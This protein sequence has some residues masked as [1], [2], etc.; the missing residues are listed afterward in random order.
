MLA[1]G[2]FGK[3]DIKSAWKAG[4]WRWASGVRKP[5]FLLIAVEATWE[6]MAAF[7]GHFAQ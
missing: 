4:I 7:E 3:A 2:K 6:R 5:R 1:Q